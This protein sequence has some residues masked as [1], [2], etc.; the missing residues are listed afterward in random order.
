MRLMMLLLALLAATPAAAQQPEW[1][2]APEYDVLLA[3]FD[4]A[5]DPIRIPA[6][7]PVKLR[8]VNQG[9]ATYSF[10]ARDLFG[11]AR[12][13]PWDADFVGPD[14]HFRLGPGER[15]TIALVVPPGRY[16]ARSANL[17]HRLLGMTGTI[18][19]E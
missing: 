15:R 18:V 13:R 11:A 9:Q 5:P 6:N 7:R 8:F 1:R 17:L 4:I 16:R 14:G 3:P 19:A 2:T 10:S 12:I